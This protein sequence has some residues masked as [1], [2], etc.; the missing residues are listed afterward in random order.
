MIVAM[1]HHEN[2]NEHIYPIRSSFSFEAFE[3][4]V[5]HP[6]SSPPHAA[7]KDSKSDRDDVTDRGKDSFAGLHLSAQGFVDI[8]FSKDALLRPLW[9]RSETPTKLDYFEFRSVLLGQL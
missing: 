8:T 6:S 5:A 2:V 3:Q 7:C 9:E 1:A 4:F